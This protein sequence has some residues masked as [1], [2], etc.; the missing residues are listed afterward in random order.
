MCGRVAAERV[1]LG[2]REIVVDQAE[3]VEAIRSA[4]VNRDQSRTA[5]IG[6]DGFMSSGK[7]TL[8]RELARQL[9]AVHLEIDHYAD[10]AREATSYIGKLRVSEL[11][12]DFTTLSL[13]NASLIIEGVC[14]RRVLC[15]IG[16]R[17]DVFVYVKRLS[18]AGL[19]HDGLHLEDFASETPDSDDWL[20]TDVNSYHLI[21]RPHERA[22]I[23]FERHELNGAEDDG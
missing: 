11:A 3:T 12:A 23:I 9:G 16:V 20:N 13:A 8:S 21:C 18:Q 7:S 19:W 22:D 1:S 2:L 4:I 14:L 10:P 17:A 6:V 5:V 15:A